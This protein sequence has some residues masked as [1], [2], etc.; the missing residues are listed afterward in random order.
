MKIDFLN[1]NK[2]KGLGN[3]KAALSNKKKG[4]E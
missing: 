4:V 2:K 1:N 3:G